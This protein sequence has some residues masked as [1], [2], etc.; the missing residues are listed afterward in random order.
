MGVGASVKRKASGKV[1][2]GKSTFQNIED[3]YELRNP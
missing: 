3:V 2:Q 1:K